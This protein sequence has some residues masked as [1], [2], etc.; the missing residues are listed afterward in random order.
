MN[1]SSLR[2][3][4]LDGY[5]R[6]TL[7]ADLT[8]GVTV[9]FMLV[10]QAMAY[11]MLAVDSVALV[12]LLTATAVGAMQV[13]MGFLRLGY[14]VNVVNH[15]EM[16]TVPGVLALR[17]DAAFYFGNVTFLKDTLARLEDESEVPLTAVV[18]EA[19]AINA[20]DST[21]AHAL[22]SITSKVHFASLARLPRLPRHELHP[23]S[24]LSPGACAPAACATASSG[25]WPAAPRLETSS[26]DSPGA[27]R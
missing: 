16:V 22:G 1:I 4:W 24:P 17:F 19:A 5:S 11:A 14:L 12:S 7:A 26:P 21:A 18:L 23:W 13:A 20:L 6:D 3:A 2:P 27:H 8:A 15:S 10:P 25:S 9:A